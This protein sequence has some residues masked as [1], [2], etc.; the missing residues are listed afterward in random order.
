[1]SRRKLPQDDSKIAQCLTYGLFRKAAWPGSVAFFSK[2]LAVLHSDEMTSSWFALPNQTFKVFSF[3]L[4]HAYGIPEAASTGNI[5]S[6]R[7]VKAKL[8]SEQVQ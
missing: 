1:M 7:H 3:D 8:Q 2:Q 6:R 5:L 4:E